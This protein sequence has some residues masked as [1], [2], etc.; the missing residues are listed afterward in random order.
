MF[1][2]QYDTDVTTWSPAGRLFQVEYAMEAVKQGS[3]AIGLRSKTHVVLASINKANS[4][5]SSH[6]KKIFKA[7]DHIGIAIAG[8]TADGRVLSRYLRSECINYSFTYESPLP[9]GRLVVQLADKAQVCTQRSWK[10]P[11]GVGLLVAGLDESGAHLY[12]NCPSGN[13]FEYQAFAIGS[14]SQAAKTYLERKYET[15]MSSSREELIKHALFAIKETLQGEKLTSSICTVAVVAVDEPFHVIDQNAITELVESF[16][17]QE[18][19]AE[20]TA[21]AGDMQEDQGQQIAPMDI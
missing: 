10:R 8:L 13:Y 4:E 17:I 7:D 6:Q 15:F 19:T 20:A 18:E 5:L 1:R 21:P 3:A 14:R 2:N 11:Y 16:E 12:Y 9:V